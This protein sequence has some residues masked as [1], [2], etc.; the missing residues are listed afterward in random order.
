VNSLRHACHGLVVQ[1]GRPCTLKP[2]LRTSHSR[3]RQMR[4]RPS[5][6]GLLRRAPEHPL[7][8]NRLRSGRPAPTS[9]RAKA[10]IRGRRPRV[11]AARSFEAADLRAIGQSGS[12][13]RVFIA[14]GTSAVPELCVAWRRGPRRRWSPSDTWPHSPPTSFNAGPAGT[15]TPAPVVTSTGGPRAMANGRCGTWSS[16][17]RR[18]SARRPFAPPRDLGHPAGPART[19]RP[20]SWIYDRR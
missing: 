3:T 11:G 17:T 5:A 1:R 8:T 19:N 20:P 2:A 15:S 10:P 7:D 6:D 14:G 9:A 13:E 12:R 4:L 16:S 18:S